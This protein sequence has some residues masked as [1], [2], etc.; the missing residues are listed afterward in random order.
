MFRRLHSRVTKFCGQDTDSPGL[1]RLC[2]P[3]CLPA[4]ASCCGPCWRDHP[5]GDRT[6]HPIKT[7]RRECAEPLGGNPGEGLTF[8]AHRIPVSKIV[9]V[10]MM[11]ADYTTAVSEAAPRTETLLRSIVISRTQRTGAHIPRTHLAAEGRER[12]PRAAVDLQGVPVPLAVSR[13]RAARP[14]WL[15]AMLWVIPGDSYSLLSTYQGAGAGPSIWHQL[16]HL[17]LQEPRGVCFP[18]PA[19]QGNGWAVWWEGGPR[20]CHPTDK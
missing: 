17:S 13:A 9:Q 5:E 19:L 6:R 4:A 2:A 7:R 10:R 1:G 14:Q 15:K 20:P 16:P 3:T 11:E 12:A 8:T 18:L